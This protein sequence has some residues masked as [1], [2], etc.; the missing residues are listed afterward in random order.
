MK[1][2]MT[3]LGRG[4]TR[5]LGFGLVCIAFGAIGVHAASLTVNTTADAGPGSLRQAMLDATVNT[6]ANIVTFAVPTT[7]PGFNAGT[8]MFTISLLSP[9]PDIPL[10]AMTINNLQSQ[11]ITVN[12]NNSF[13]VFTLVNSAV[14]TINNLTIAGGFSS[15][16]GGGIFMGNSGTLTLNGCTLRNN[17]ASASGGGIYMANSGTVTLINSTIRNNAA[18]NGGAVYVF[19]SGTIN[20]TNSTINANIANNGGSGG[21][22]YIGTSGTINATNSTFDGNSASLNGGGIYNTS[23]AATATLINT[24]ITGNTAANGGGFYNSA[25][26]TLTN[27]LIAL[28]TAFDGNDVVGRASLGQDRKSVV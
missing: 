11:G 10:A 7:D 24:T 14:L 23:T 6:E 21:G 15:T 17:T 28:N 2:I 22:I 4:L 26:A 12:A 16:L 20:V 5:Y 1:Y 25:T 18:I 19:D 27:N 13:R 3:R 8:N 9:L